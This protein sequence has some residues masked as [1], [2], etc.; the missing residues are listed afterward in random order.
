MEA[1]D[2]LRFTVRL[3]EV[4]AEAVAGRLTA[5]PAAVA[6]VSTPFRAT[7]VAVRDTRRLPH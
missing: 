6:A 2:R 1:A 3:T 4:P 5:I 7:L